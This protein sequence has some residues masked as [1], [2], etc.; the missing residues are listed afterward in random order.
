SESQADATVCASNQDGSDGVL[1][2]WSVYNRTV[3]NKTFI[4]IRTRKCDG[5]FDAAEAL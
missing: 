5:A 2:L 4:L 3:F 1:R